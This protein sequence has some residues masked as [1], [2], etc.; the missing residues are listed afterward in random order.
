[1]LFCFAL[2]PHP[3]IYSAGVQTVTLSVRSVAFRSRR[4]RRVSPPPLE[5]RVPRHTHTHPHTH[6]HKRARARARTHQKTTNDPVKLMSQPRAPAPQAGRQAAPEARQTR[7][8]IPTRTSPSCSCL[9]RCP[10]APPPPSAGIARRT[11]DWEMAGRIP[12]NSQSSWL[13]DPRFESAARHASSPD[14]CFLRSYMYVGTPLTRFRAPWGAP[15][16]APV[17]AFAWRRRLFSAHTT[18]VSWPHRELHLRTHR[19]SVSHLRLGESI[20][21]AFPFFPNAH[22]EPTWTI[23]RNLRGCQRP[24]RNQGPSGTLSSLAAVQPRPPE[25]GGWRGMPSSTGKNWF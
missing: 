22:I 17:G 20:C 5:T 3:A 24:S 1:M 2:F 9:S 7:E 15:P 13:L 14:F 18:H 4:Q 21:W 11:C 6:T 25:R 12:S 10:P 16:Q 8:P 19:D 23:L